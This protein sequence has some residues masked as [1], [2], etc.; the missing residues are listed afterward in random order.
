[1]AKRAAP[2]APAAPTLAS[3]TQNSVTLTP[4][5]AN[6]FSSNG[7]EWQASNVFTGL[8]ANTTYTFYQRIA[9]TADALPSSAS[10]GLSVTTDPPPFLPGTQLP[11]PTGVYVSNGGLVTWNSV[12][13]VTNY[14]ISIYTQ[15]GITPVKTLA[16]SRIILL[17]IYSISNADI[18]GAITS[19]GYYRVTVTANGNGTTFRDSEPSDYSS[20][21]MR[22]YSVSLTTVDIGSTDSVSLNN[23]A[24]TTNSTFTVCALSGTTMQFSA[25]AGS[26]RKVIISGSRTASG[27]FT[28]NGNMEITAEF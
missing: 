28:V 5:A 6:E 21:N 2:A 11:A 16:T 22:A 7:T 10:A 27:N 15:N 3:K 4:N 1:M 9:E 17:P 25:T 18:A 8:R 26:G 14:T 23:V 24:R 13:N 20:A 12:D 19:S